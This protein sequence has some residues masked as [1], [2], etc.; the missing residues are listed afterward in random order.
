LDNRAIHRRVAKPKKAASRI[1]LPIIE[2]LD[3]VA[4]MVKQITYLDVV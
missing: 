2:Y 4:D 3:T 1:A